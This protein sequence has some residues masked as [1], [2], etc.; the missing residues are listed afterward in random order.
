M[1]PKELQASIVAKNRVNDYVKQYAPQI[2]ADLKQFEG[3]KIVLASGELAAP[4]KKAIQGFFG[5]IQ[6]GGGKTIQI[7]PNSLG[8]SLSLVFKSSENHSEFSCV[9]QESSV[10]FADLN[11]GILTK[12]YEFTPEN[13]RS[14]YFLEEILLIQKELEEAEEKVSEIQGKLPAFARR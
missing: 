3:K 9:Y 2:F 7:Y 14:D 1:N 8:Y 13:F 11:N 4:V 10:Y 6:V 12:F 5:N